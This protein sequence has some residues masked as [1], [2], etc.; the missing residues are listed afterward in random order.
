MS[1]DSKRIAYTK[2]APQPDVY[3]SKLQASGS[4]EEPQRLT[5]DDR[6]DLPFDW[7]TDNKSVIFIS[8]RT[9]P[10]SIY[11]QSV[12][13]TVPEL[14]VSGGQQHL[15]EPRL[16]PDGTQILY[17]VNHVWGDATADVPLMSVPLAG[18]AAREIARAKWISN[19]QCARAP[20][21]TCIFSVITE[22]GL[23]FFRFDPLKGPGTEVFQVNDDLAQL[24][25]WSLSPDGTTLAI[26]KGKG[27]EEEPRIHLLSL[28]GAPEKWLT[29]HGWPGV[30]SLDW[31]ADSKS[32]WAATTGEKE[33]ALLRIDLRGNIRTVWRPKQVR[34]G[35]AIPSRDGKSVAVHI[36][37]SSA[38]V[39]MLEH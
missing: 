27:G 12:D 2:E 28:V 6:Q 35:W 10:F 14:L 18:G 38:N 21:D 22:T 13:Q 9:G 39:W 30:S 1:G 16:S 32:L 15:M 34:V 29:I 7:T 11:K 5:L 37:S 4:L 24:Y 3:V 31:A 19:H 8:D 33:N 25:N 20:A 17:L 23:T 36:D 26:A